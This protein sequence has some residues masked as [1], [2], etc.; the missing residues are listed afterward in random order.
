MR[1]IDGDALLNT[2]LEYTIRGGAESICDCAEFNRMIK[3][4]KS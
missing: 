2:L 1:L 4:A 3:D